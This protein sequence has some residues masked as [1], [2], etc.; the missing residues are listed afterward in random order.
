MKLGFYQSSLV[1]KRGDF[2]PLSV[3][4]GTKVHYLKGTSKE[5]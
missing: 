3:I 5:L 1:K 4:T 2:R